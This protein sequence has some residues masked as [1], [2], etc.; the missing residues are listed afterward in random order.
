LD[1]L[2]ALLSP[3]IQSLGF[4]LL[5]C[6]LSGGNKRQCLRVYIDKPGSGISLGDCGMVSRQVAALLDVEDVIQGPYTLQVSSPGVDRPLFS[7]PH[8]QA[9]IGKR[10]RVRLH[11]RKPGRHNYT[12][13]LESIEGAVLSVVVDGDRHHLPYDDIESGHVVGLP[14]AKVGKTGVI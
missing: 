7:L 8:Y 2:D 12:G 9:A 13:Q 10:I 5:G 4:E 6:Q 14:D 1:Q 3:S 11:K